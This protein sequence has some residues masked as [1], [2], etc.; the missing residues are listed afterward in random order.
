[1]AEGE[2]GADRDGALAVCYEAARH[3]VD[4]LFGAEV[5][6]VGVEGARGEERRTEIW[7]ASR[8]WRR[9]SVYASTAVPAS[10]LYG[11]VVERRGQALSLETY[12]RVEMLHSRVSTRPSQSIFL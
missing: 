2:K 6:L 8:A 5:L 12:L 10:G 11:W 3:E 9:P 1:M 7:S 4:G